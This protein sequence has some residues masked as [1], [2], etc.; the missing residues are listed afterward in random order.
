[1]DV[2]S[3]AASFIALVA[4]VGW[5]N[6]RFLR[7]PSAVAMMAA[8]S[9]AA[10]AITW[11][12]SSTVVS[13]PSHQA[14]T[15]L[16]QLDFADATITYMLGFL[17]FAG[18]M[19]VDFAELR[20]RWAPVLS[21]AT[22]GVV[23]ST[24]IVGFG[25]W[26]LAGLTGAHLPLTW[27]LVFGALISPT[28]PVAVLA[29]VRQGKFSKGLQSILQGEALFNDGVAIVVFTGAV[30]VASLG[31]DR[32]PLVELGRVGLEAGGGA[33]LGA[34]SG[35]IVV[36]AMRAIDDYAIEVALSLA[37]AMGAY[38]AATNVHL[39]GPIAVVVAGLIVGERGI[40]RAMSETTQRYMQGFWSLVDE[41]LNAFVFL[42]LGL[43]LAVIHIAWSQ[44]A[45]LIT[46]IALVLFARALIVLPWGLSLRGDERGAGPVLMWGG[47]HGAL[48]VALALLTPEGPQL[49][50]I[51]SLTF[52]VAAFSVVVQGLT[53][54]PLAERLAPVAES[55]K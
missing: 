48:S 29:A 11:G 45:L 5:V 44:A 55:K 6:A 32:S 13:E 19:Q 8:G 15:V 2:F 14:T 35:L 16:R 10:V 20:R 4:A 17:L 47:M 51:L 41:L 33:F 50:L 46:A 31:E 34:V 42:L 37:L 53:F 27:A 43:E 30:A 1:M 18:A 3:I 25:T 23:A 54:S 36:E 39:S 12:R 7:V 52:A 9:V 49:A 26:L 38:A 40:K 28:D 21:L 24:V 22:L